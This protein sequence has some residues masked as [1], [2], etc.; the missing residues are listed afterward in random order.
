MLLIFSRKF[1]LDLILDEVSLK[2]INNIWFDQQQSL[3]SRPLCVI[4]KLHNHKKW[5]NCKFLLFFSIPNSQN[6]DRASVCKVQNKFLEIMFKL[7]C[8]T[9]YV[10][11]IL[12]ALDRP[13]IY[14]YIILYTLYILTYS[15]KLLSRVFT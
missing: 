4:R 6:V 8:P 7:F 9:F 11:I 12:K 15:K 14:F 5:P 10:Q 3:N 1:Y 13:W 2:K